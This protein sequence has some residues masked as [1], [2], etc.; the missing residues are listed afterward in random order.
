[1]DALTREQLNM[2]VTSFDFGESVENIEK[3]EERFKLYFGKG[4]LREFDENGVHIAA[5]YTFEDGAPNHAV[6]I[7][8]WDD[9]VPVSYF[10]AEHQPPGPGAWIVKNSW[11][12][13]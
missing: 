2:L 10:N 3:R 6:T 12:E 8:G 9:T 4:Y 5:H 1:M 7:V 13:N 11:G